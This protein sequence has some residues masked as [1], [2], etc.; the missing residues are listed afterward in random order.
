VNAF[1]V[2]A[3]ARRRGIT[4]VRFEYCDVSGI[5]HCKAIHVDRL[6]QKLLEGVN[7]T[8]AQMSI[9]ML[10][11]VVPVDGME[12][13]GEIRLLPDLDTFS[14]LPW[15][16]ASAGMLCDQVGHD[17]RNWGA[18]PRTYLKDVIGQTAAHGI[19][20]R[21][22][23]ENE[24]YLAREE[25]G[26]FIPFDVPGHAPVYSS[27][28]H[29][30]TAEVMIETIAALEAQGMVV[31]QAI[32]EYGPGQQEISVGHTD[33]LRAADNQVKFRDAVRGVASRHG[34]LASFAAKPFPDQIG[35]GAHVHLSL[36]DV[37]S[38]RNLVYDQ[39]AEGGLSVLGRRFIAGVTD[40]LPA[41]TA[42]TTPSYNSFRRL[43]P[44]AWAAA[45]TAWGFDNREAAVRVCSPF[46]GREEESY[47]LEFKTSDG[48]ANP[49]LSL[50]A[51]I[52]CGLDG[53][54]RGLEPGE[55]SAHDPVR[56]AP[57]ELERGRVRPLPTT[58]RAA[59]NELEKDEVLLGSMEKLLA[60]CY[61][62]VR[63]AE[64]EEF[65]AQD[66]EFEIRNH[67]YRF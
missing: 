37:E 45:T 21:A 1:K 9:N 62:A 35:S 32:N 27:I 25:D 13:V 20:V 56:M 14:V 16:S 17:R 46:H 47:N 31:E 63:R 39:S 54:A 53:I 26:R 23:F 10:E 57:G 3:E 28:G 55:P 42:L 5:A 12:P 15:A 60:R 19:L 34:L 33:A 40:H 50:G 48:S 66:E 6:Q 49:Y 67:F 11:H 59:L 8:R 7:L 65:S 64:D 43:R 22:S 58:M 2:V 30:L 52:T 41:L 18:C 24:Y 61:L 4:L 44:S 51:L 29:D 36:W 38:G